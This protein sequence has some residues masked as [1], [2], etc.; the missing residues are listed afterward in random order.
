[1]ALPSVADATP[2]F[3]EMALSTPFRPPAK[4]GATT[5]SPSTTAPAPVA[6]KAGAYVACL[7]RRIASLCGAHNPR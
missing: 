2:A 1:M 5:A 7:A 6:Q 4:A 3:T